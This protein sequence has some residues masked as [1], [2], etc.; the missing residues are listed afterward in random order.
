MIKALKTGIGVAVLAA[1]VWP[2]GASAG[3]VTFELDREF[4]GADDPAGPTPWLTAT[5]DD[6]GSPGSVRLTMEATNLVGNEFVSR[7]LF[8]VKPTIDPT[9]LGVAFTDIANVGLSSLTLG[10]DCC[11]ADGDGFFDMQFN[12]NNGAFTSGESAVIDFSK[13]GL[14]AEDFDFLSTGAGNSPEGL[15]TAAHVQG[16]GTNDEGSGWITGVD[17]NG[18]NLPEPTS[19][20]L[21]GAGLLGL[22]GVVRARRRR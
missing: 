3:V 6:G 19:M 17:G 12:F 5:F 20:L 9:T 8:N 4:S 14:K 10:F 15:A 22:G 21:I 2:L 1:M 11:K 18:R 16:I 7:W 13:P